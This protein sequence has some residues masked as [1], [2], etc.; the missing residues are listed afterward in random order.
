MREELRRCGWTYAEL[1]KRRPTDAGKVRIA[2]RLRAE[3]VMTLDWVAERLQMECQNR[4][5]NCLKGQRTCQYAGLTYFRTDCRTATIGG[6]GEANQVLESRQ[7]HQQRTSTV[8]GHADDSGWNGPPARR[9][10]RPARRSATLT[11][12]LSQLGAS[13]R[14]GPASVTS[15]FSM[16]FRGETIT[17]RT[18]EPAMLCCM[19]DRSLAH[20]W[21]TALLLM[22]VIGSLAFMLTRPVFGQ[23]PQYHDFADQRAFLGVPNFFDVISNVWFL[24]VG[25]TGLRLCLRGRL[26]GGGAPWTVF[27]LGVAWVSVGSAYYHWRPS[28]E[29]LVWD[30]LPMTIAFMAMFVALLSESV[31]E[32]LARVLLIPALL[33]GIASVIYWNMFDDLRFYAWVQMLPLLTIPVVMLLFRSRYSHQ[34]LLPVALSLYILAKV[35]EAYD[36]QILNLN[37]GFVG[38]HPVKHVLAAACCLVISE[39]LRRRK[40]IQL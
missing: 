26:A 15:F 34:S 39:M 28:N 22:I 36:R 20:H 32:R 17:H 25:L 21:R 40:Q 6:A 14:L 37:H 16:L 7:I 5:A 18:K 24:L 3:T 35:A 4:L 27:F 23:D 30:R 19:N 12:N 1:G 11:S 8:M 9:R 33:V 13:K 2:V 10:G 38:G 29:T 31:D